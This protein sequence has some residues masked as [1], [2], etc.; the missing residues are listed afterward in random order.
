V[1]HYDV[2]PNPRWRTVAILKIE[3]AQSL[4]R[5]SSDLHQIL[6]VDV[7]P[8]ICI[9]WRRAGLSASAELL[10]FIVTIINDST[11]IWNKICHLSL[12]VLSHYLTYYCSTFLQY[13]AAV[14]FR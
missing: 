8:I 11:H 6:Q 2:I 10:V 9:T 7:D 14:H 1:V 13:R 5:G 3:N 12:T 4:G